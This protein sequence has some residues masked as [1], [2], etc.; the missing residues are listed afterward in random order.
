MD[1]VRDILLEIDKTPELDGSRWVPGENITIEGHSR[2]EL[3]Y[4]LNMLVEAGFIRGEYTMDAP[5]IS[6]LTWQGHEFLDNV[7]D[8]D[9][10]SKTK[11]RAKKLSAIGLALLGELAKAEIKKKLGLA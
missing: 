2:E 5:L 8:P 10:W 4:H 3:A 7:R 6:K 9:I 11:E 1:L